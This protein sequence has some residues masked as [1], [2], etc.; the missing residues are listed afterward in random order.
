[1]S[2]L[3]LVTGLTDTGVSGLVSSMAEEFGGRLD[4]TVAMLLAEDAPDGWD[5]IHC[6][7]DGWEQA[8]TGC[9]SCETGHLLSGTVLEMR[10]RSLP[11][12]LLVALAPTMEIGAVR[13]SMLLSGAYRLEE[14]L[15]V[16]VVDV[17][18]GRDLYR[19]LDHLFVAMATESDLLVLRGTD[20]CCEAD[21][22]AAKDVALGANPNLWVTALPVALDDSRPGVAALT[23]EL[24]ARQGASR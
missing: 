17:G 7:P 6:P 1:M 5:S 8:A 23:A 19:E 15:A 20:G 13:Q 14:V 22:G 10:G 24:L 4:R 3:V 21:F 9:A 12:F 11:D 16:L 18:P 2:R